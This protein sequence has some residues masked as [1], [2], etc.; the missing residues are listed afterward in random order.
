MVAGA[1]AGR[2]RDPAHLPCCRAAACRGQQAATGGAPLPIPPCEPRQALA[3]PSPAWSGP[4][5]VDVPVPSELQTYFGGGGGGLPAV[6]RVV[7]PGAPGGTGSPSSWP[8]SGRLVEKGRPVCSLQ[9]C[10]SPA[11]PKNPPQRAQS[12]TSF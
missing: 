9:Q 4:K 10:K 8:H 12:R 6:G 7:A 11:T 2:D 5:R 1:Q 3:P